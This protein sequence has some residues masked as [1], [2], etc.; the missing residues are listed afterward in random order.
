LRGGRRKPSRGRIEGKK[1][2]KKKTNR[3]SSRRRLGVV[4]NSVAMQH[5]NLKAMEI[6]MFP[7]TIYII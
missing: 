1:D 2:K 6:D 4:E 5:Y 7:Y 3:R